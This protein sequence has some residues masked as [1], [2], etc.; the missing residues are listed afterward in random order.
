[1]TDILFKGLMGFPLL[2]FVGS[3]LALVATLLPGFLERLEPDV[4]EG[5]LGRERELPRFPEIAA[6]PPPARKA[7]VPVFAAP[8]EE[9]DLVAA[10]ALALTLYLEEGKRTGEFMGRIPAGNPWAVAGRWQA[11]QARLQGRKR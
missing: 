1:M 3:L 11:M 2:L 6:H 4:G 8:P 9:P 10:I 7:P 5:P